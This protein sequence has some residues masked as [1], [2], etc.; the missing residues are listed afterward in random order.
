M[1]GR[2]TDVCQ[3]HSVPAAPGAKAGTVVSILLTPPEKKW[4]SGAPTRLCG[5]QVPVL[6]LRSWRLSSGLL[7][8]LGSQGRQRGPAL[9][10][11]WTQTVPQPSAGGVCL[12]RP[13]VQT[14]EAFPRAPLSKEASEPCAV[15]RVPGTG[16]V[17]LRSPFPRAAPVPGSF[18]VR[19]LSDA[20]LTFGSGSITPGNDKSPRQP[21]GPLPLLPWGSLEEPPPR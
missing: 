12:L 2:E 10:P 19:H 9:T 20:L 1:R 13:R 21:P 5:L 15:A 16:S 18:P 7:S 4:L 3:D 8:Q 11:P 14:R 6:R 17:F